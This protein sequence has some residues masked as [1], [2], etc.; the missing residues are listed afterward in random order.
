MI[1]EHHLTMLAASGITPEFAELRGYETIR[2]PRRLAELGIAKAGQ[3]TQGLLIPQHSARGDVWGHAYR[4]DHPRERNGKPA[5]YEMPY[6]QANHIDVPVGVGPTLADPSKPL[7][8]TEGSKKAD[9][10]ALR[11]VYCV[12]INGVAGWR[13]TNAAGGKTAVADFNDIALNGRDVVLAFDGDVA[14]KPPVQA[15]LCKLAE[16]LKFKGA[17]VAYL[18]LPDTDE[19]TG[20]DDYLVS[21]TVDELWRLVKP[22]PAPVTQTPEPPKVEAPR[23]APVQPVSLDEV[24]DGY[25]AAFGDKYDLDAINI[26]LAV[27]AVEKLDGD[28][29]WL[30]IVSGSGAAKTETI[31]P[32]GNCAGAITVS[33][34]SSEGAFLSASGQHERSA[35]ATGGLLREMGDRGILIFK[36]FTS[37]L[38]MSR[39]RRDDVLKALRE[40]Y[41]GYWR[42]QVGTDGGRSIEWKG[43]IVVIGAVTSAYDRAREVISKLGDRFVLLRVNSNDAEARKD[44]AKSA[45]RGVGGEKKMRADLARLVAGL[46]ENIDTA[47]AINPDDNEIDAIIN[48]ADLVTRARTAVDRAPNGEVEEAHMLEMPTR[49]PKELVQIFR[50]ATAIGLGRDAAMRLVIRAARDSMPPLKLEIVDWL[51][52]HTSGNANGVAVGVDKPYNTTN[53]QLQELHLLGVVT[54]VKITGSDSQNRWHYRLADGIDPAVLKSGA[55]SRFGPSPGETPPDQQESGAYLWGVRGSKPNL[56]SGLRSLLNWTI[57]RLRRRSDP[58]KPPLSNTSATAPGAASTAAKTNNPPAGH[59]AI[60]ATASTRTS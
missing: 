35:D 2:D 14:R 10:A 8:I 40:I 34:I 60:N 22:I 45:V 21:H 1:A 42:R 56:E 43:R 39:D 31:V 17:R 30:L 36:D 54:R 57:T 7:M 26:T 19:K 13:G 46:V 41:D 29:V 47:A 24:H 16:Y 52:V 4:P 38:A 50:G 44:A 15:E 3:R 32:L 48:A 9:C 5:K 53:R 28:P 49:Y 51:A 23:P 25:R 6:R 58:G 37:I 27:A 18:H 55:I 20:L 33:T 59:A 11:G 12:S